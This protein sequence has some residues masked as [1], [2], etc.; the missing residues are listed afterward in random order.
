LNG[1][2]IGGGTIDHLVDG[3]IQEGRPLDQIPA[4]VAGHNTG[5]L[6]VCLIG[7]GDGLP[8]G[9]GYIS[10]AMWES[11]VRLCLKWHHEFKV[12]IENFLGHR[13]FPNVHKSCPGFEVSVLRDE[14]QRRL[15]SP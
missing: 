14:L 11:L 1:R 9:E 6:A 10:R 3:M 8:V 12:P 4:A 2:L 7:N 15:T 5:M 13:E